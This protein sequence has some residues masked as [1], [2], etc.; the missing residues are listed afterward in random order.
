MCH[1]DEYGEEER[2]KKMVE[3]HMVKQTLQVVKDSQ[4]SRKGYEFEPAAGGLYEWIWS[5]TL[6][7]GP[8]HFHMVIRIV[9]QEVSE[10]C[11]EIRV[12][13]YN[14]DC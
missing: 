13:R 6:P 10:D 2:A 8:T 5:V 12:T 7:Y 3:D 1:F 4:Y 9:V 11:H 14:Q